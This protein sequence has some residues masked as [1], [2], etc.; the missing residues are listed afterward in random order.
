VLVN[1]ISLFIPCHNEGENI[2]EIVTSALPVLQSVTKD[3]EIIVI[4]DGSDDKTAEIA[5]GLGRQC[6]RIRL[7]RH[8]TNRGYAEAIKSGIRAST[9]ELIAFI[10]GDGQLDVRELRSLVEPIDL[11]DM[12]IGY[13]IK[14][15]D[16]LLR[17]AN[18]FVFNSLVR[19]IFGLKVRDV[20]C[21]LKLFRRCVFNAF[22]LRST[23][24]FINAEILIRSVACKFSLK[25]I[26]VS[27]YPR[28]CGM[29]TGARI[30][31]IIRALQDVV[32][33]YNELRS[34]RKRAHRF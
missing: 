22:E 5:E 29:Q 13:R 11:F 25:E 14:R 27:H 24:A 19:L 20:N 6:E 2:E 12:V 28:I 18:S 17:K 9:K 7:V 4:D 34:L 32:S 1:S 33:L 8:C 16:N 21:A 30:N 31:V 3:F 15:S 10:D 26:P 23:G